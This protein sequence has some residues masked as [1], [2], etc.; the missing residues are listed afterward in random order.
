MPPQP[1]PSPLTASTSA[2]A[3]YSL[4]RWADSDGCLIWDNA[5]P[6]QPWPTNYVTVNKAIPTFV[7]ALNMKTSML[8]SGACRF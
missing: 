8:A 6:T 2:N 5:F 4:V 7:E 3:S 1:L